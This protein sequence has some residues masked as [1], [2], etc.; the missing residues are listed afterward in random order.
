MPRKPYPSDVTPEQFATISEI[1]D[2]GTAKTKPRRVDTR[3]VFCAI[4][5][6]L[7]SGCQWRMLPSDFPHWRTC[8]GYWARWSKPDKSPQG[9]AL[10]RALKKSGWR[11]PREPWAQ[12]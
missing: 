10:G 12:P 2:S 4:L 1:L 3:E 6:L 7:R 8:Y 5:Y 11:G 9:S